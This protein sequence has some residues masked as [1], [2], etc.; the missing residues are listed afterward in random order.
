MHMVHYMFVMMSTFMNKSAC[1]LTK[2][3]LGQAL[4]HVL[5]ICNISPVAKH[6]FFEGPGIL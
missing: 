6:L 4:I 2:R 5:Q 1:W 3:S